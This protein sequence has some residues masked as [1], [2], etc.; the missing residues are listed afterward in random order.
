MNTYYITTGIR[1]M[2]KP[3]SVHVFLPYGK[4]PLLA[5]IDGKKSAFLPISRKVAE[6]LIAEGYS[7]GD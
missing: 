5:V 2:E 7:Y 3:E 1:K 4:K 6:V